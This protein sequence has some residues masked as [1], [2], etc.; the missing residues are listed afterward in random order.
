MSVED[1]FFALLR[2]ER[3]DSVR[4]QRLDRPGRGEDAA[5]Q[6][7]ISPKS[8]L[9]KPCHSI[10]RTPQAAIRRAMEEWDSQFAGEADDM[11]VEDLLG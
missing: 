7:I 3:L 10:L 8:D 5:F 9:G 4:L 11:D 6:A 2:D 1:R